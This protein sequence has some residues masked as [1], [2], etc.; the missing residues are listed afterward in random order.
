MQHVR[1]LRY[2]KIDTFSMPVIHILKRADLGFLGSFDML[3]LMIT[4]L[5]KSACLE[6]FL[7]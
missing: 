4:I 3:F 7:S 1:V 2:L 5:K 6:F